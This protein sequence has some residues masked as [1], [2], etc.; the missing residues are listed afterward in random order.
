ML[1]ISICAIF[2]IMFLA[3]LR[4]FMGPSLY[5][6]ILAVN[7]FGTKT[8]LFIALLGAL[9]EHSYFLDIAMLYALLNFVSMVGVLRFFE[10]QQQAQLKKTSKEHL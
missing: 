5:D 9:F 6:R 10:Y 7:L 8:V 4:A 3:L 2:F 1:L